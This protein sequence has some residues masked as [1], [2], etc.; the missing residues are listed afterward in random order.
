MTTQEVFTNYFTFLLQMFESDMRIL[1]QGWMYYWLLIPVSFYL[2][3]FIL[4]W[5]I[6]TCPIWMPFS[7][8]VESL[9]YLFKENE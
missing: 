7:I 5:F 9:K 8:I 3:F 1:S 6:L 2:M 4:K